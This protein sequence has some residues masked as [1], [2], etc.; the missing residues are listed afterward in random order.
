M[1]WRPPTLKLRSDGTARKP[2]KVLVSEIMLQQTQVSR[3][4]EKYPSFIKRFPTFKALAEASQ[5]NVLEEWMGLGYNRRGLNLKR[6]AEIVTRDR[7]GKLPR[8]R[9]ELVTLPGIGPATAGA[10]R[11]YVWNEPDVFIETNIRTVYIYHFFNEAVDVRDADLMPI[12]E[13]TLDKN[14]PRGWYYALMDY[15]T[16][17]KTR[18]GNSSRTSRHYTKQ[19]PFIGSN[20]AVR[21]RILTLLLAKPYQTTAALKKQIADQ[22]T[23]ANVATLER[24][25]MIARKKTR[26]FVPE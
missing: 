7:H 15:G 22:R 23:E 13:N 16:D 17:L 20:R 1:P 6:T 12:I 21:S 2:Y 3:V 14:N 4:M 25:G 5:R 26:Y 24:E 11:A 9:E 19:S 8:L 18:V 10:L